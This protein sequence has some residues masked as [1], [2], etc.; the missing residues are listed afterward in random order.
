MQTARKFNKARVLGRFL[1]TAALLAATAT[2]AVAPASATA[3]NLAKKPTGISRCLGLW[4]Q[5]NRITLQHQ[6]GCGPS[7]SYHIHVWSPGHDTNTGT[8]TYAGATLTFNNPWPAAA[9]TNICA[10]LWHH[11]PGGGYSSWGLPC[12]PM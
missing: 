5:N 9:G 12:D 3:T 8:Y 11:E 4:A 7:G 2:I 6:P 10:E 1:T